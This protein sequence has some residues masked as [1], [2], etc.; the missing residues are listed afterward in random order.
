MQDL[1]LPPAP[2][3]RPLPPP[4]VRAA[5]WPPDDDDFG[6]APGGGSPIGGGFT[7]PDGDFKKGKLKP[8]VVLLILALIAGGAAAFLLI[9]TSIDEAKITP[10]KAA[11]VRKQ[12][13]MLPQRDQVAEWRKWAASDESAYLKEEAL[14]QLAWARDPAGVDLAIA[15]LSHP[16]EKIRAQAALALGEYGSPDAEKARG[17]LLAA[18][19]EAKAES[20]PQ[21]AW[22]LV[23]LGEAGAFDEVMSLYRLGHLATVRRLDGAAAFDPYRMVSLVSLDKLAELHKDESPAVRQLV[24]T[25]LSRNASP[26]YT[27]ALIALV[28]DP[29]KDIAAQAAPGL[30]KIGDDRAVEP[31]LE[32]LKGASVEE[33]KVFLEALRDGIGTTGLVLALDSV[34]DETP[35]KRWHQTRQIFTMIRDLADPK[36]ADALAGYLEREGNHVHWQL[37]AAFA[38]AEVGDLRSVPMLAA[39]LRMDEQKIYSDETDYEM[40]LKRNN[41]EREVAGRMLADLAVLHPDQHALMRKQAEDALIF[42]NHALPS[43]HAN[44]LRA[45]VNMGSTKDLKSLRAWADPRAPLPLEGQQPPMPQEWV[46]AQSAL[47]YIGK[48]KNKPSW[49]VLEKSLKMRPE[50]VDATMDS[51]MGGGLAILGMSLRAVGVGAAHGFAEWGDNRAFKPLLAYIEEPKNN[52]QSRL[53]ACA[54]LAWVAKPDDFVTIARKIQQYSGSTERADQVRQACLLEA[55]I[56]RPVP[57]IGEALLEMFTPEA[58]QEVRYALARAIGKAGISPEIETR[59][60]EMLGQEAMIN[61]AALALMLGG[62]PDVAARTLARFADQPREVTDELQELWYKSFG[63]WSDEDLDQGHIFRYVE[64]AEA[65]SRIQFGDMFQNWVSEQLRRQ[66]ENLQFDN[67]PR[68]FTRVVLRNRLMQMALGDDAAVRQKAIRTLKFMRERGV[69]LSLIGSEGETGELAAEAYHELLNP[70][71]VANARNFAALAEE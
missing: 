5:K 44:G 46:I 6:G 59:L 65:A 23:E 58:S 7:P 68:S 42:W 49:R 26:K 15:A 31:L 17:P 71:V 20:K 8:I 16:E 56:T 64:N 36:G 29:D 60:F 38:L 63:Y 37:Q 54:A 4:L 12:T 66:F 70:Q 27:D 67:G 2:R 10:D 33:K 22:A 19:K 34:S 30:G 32:Q 61:A 1:E 11:E 3:P 13:L 18:L 52:E 41:N 50:K 48:M 39:R 9:G 24:A 43:P 28:K 35:T 62:T 21:I 47:R 53:E 14:K 55:L 57:G 51:L 69:L 25:V 45:L 40:M